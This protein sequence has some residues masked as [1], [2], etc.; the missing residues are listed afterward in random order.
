MYKVEGPNVFS[1]MMFVPWGPQAGDYS[2]LQVTVSANTDL[3]PVAT[4]RH[5]LLKVAGPVPVEGYALVLSAETEAALLVEQRVLL[6]DAGQDLEMLLAE[7]RSVVTHGCWQARGPLLRLT[8]A[9]VDGSA[10]RHPGR[11]SC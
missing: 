7:G 9:I 1:D 2:Q 5:S 6:A 3:L 8:T 4:L 11:A 10:W